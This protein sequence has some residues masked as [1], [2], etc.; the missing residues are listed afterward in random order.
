MKVE[1]SRL[2]LLAAESADDDRKVQ[3]GV[4]TYLR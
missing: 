2:Y 3:S 1:D 4:S